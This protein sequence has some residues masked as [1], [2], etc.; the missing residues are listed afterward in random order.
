MPCRFMD[1]AIDV[2]TRRSASR[3]RWRR[4]GHDFVDWDFSA[5]L[6][7]GWTNPSVYWR[8]VKEHLGSDGDDVLDGLRM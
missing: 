4:C 8:Q 3:R 2:L 5:S 7:S 1:L 6:Y